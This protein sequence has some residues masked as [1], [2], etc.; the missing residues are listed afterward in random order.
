MKYG[1]SNSVEPVP[2]S[3]WYRVATRAIILDNQQ[4]LLVMENHDGEYELPGG[5]WEY[6]ESFRVCLEREIE[7]ELGVVLASCDEDILCMYRGRNSHGKMS[8]RIAVRAKLSSFDFKPVD[9]KRAFWATRDEFM[10]LDFIP[11]AEEELKQHADK[12]WAA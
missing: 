7:E 2:I 1:V 8:L 3:P 5:G 9:M 12:I 6:D 10:K 11:A 4:R